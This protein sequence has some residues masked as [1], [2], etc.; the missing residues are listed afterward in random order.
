MSRSQLQEIFQLGSNRNASRVMKQ[1]EPYVSAMRRADDSIYFLNKTG[2]ERVG[3]EKI[4]T[5]ST[6]YHHILLRNDIY[7]HYKPLM[8][9]NEY[10]I[11]IK[12]F[13]IIS[14]AVFMLKDKHFLLEVDNEQKMSV[15]KEKLDNYFRFMESGIWQKS[16]KG[17]FPTILFYVLSD[18][19]KARLEECNPGIPLK[20][21]T[22]KDLE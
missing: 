19:R 5:K 17:T 16:N 7:C 10:E 9:K 18:Y 3:S 12:D 1:L 20:V 8:W 4:I 15:N 22:K 21:L 13:H 11:K 14:D 6:P 2:R